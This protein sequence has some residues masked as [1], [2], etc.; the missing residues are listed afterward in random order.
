MIEVKIKP[1]K[2]GQAIGLLLRMGGGFQ[3]RYERTLIVNGEQRRNLEAAG[4]VATN[5][6]VPSPRKHRGQ[7]AK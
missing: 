6:A 1:G 3:T 2:Y 4:L 7:K 5:G